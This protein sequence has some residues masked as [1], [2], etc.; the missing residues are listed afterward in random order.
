[1]WAQMSRKGE[2]VA[3][4]RLVNGK[5][6][7]NDTLVQVY[8]EGE[9]LTFQ[10]ILFVLQHYFDS[11]HEYYPVEEGHLGKGMLLSA[12]C[13]LACGVPMGNILRRFNLETKHLEV[14][15]ARRSDPSCA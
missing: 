5:K 1:M 4:F 2:L 10:E 8:A 6:S 7:K 13:C 11:E 12:V 3:R 9:V 14:F 15:D